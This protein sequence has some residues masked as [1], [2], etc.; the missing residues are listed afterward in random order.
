MV[1]DVLMIRKTI[2]FRTQEDLDK[3]NAISNKAEWLH[4]RLN[5]PATPP[6]TAVRESVQET[7][8][9]ETPNQRADREIREETTRRMN[10]V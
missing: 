3:F 2:Y 6:V 5:W 4:N 10:N 9:Q 1:Y 8:T 7:P